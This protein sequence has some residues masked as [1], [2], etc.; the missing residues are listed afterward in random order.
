[1]ARTFDSRID[2]IRRELVGA[3]NEG[4]DVGEVIVHA[5]VA[6]QR[7]LDDHPARDEYGQTAA[8]GL[9][10]NRP[11]SWEASYVDQMLT[12]GGYYAGA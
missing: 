7:W 11:G 5:V 4:W 2:T 1:M 9:T 8:R 10:D 12:S 3:L 6:A